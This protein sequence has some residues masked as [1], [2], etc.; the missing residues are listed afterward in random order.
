[1][2]NNAVPTPEPE[3]EIQEQP[4]NNQDPA[5]TSRAGGEDDIVAGKFEENYDE[6]SIQV[7]EG[8]EAVRKRP[9]MY[10][11]DNG[12]K[13]LHQMFREVIDNSVDEA[14]AGYC[15]QIKVTLHKDN[16]MS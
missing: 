6:S 16:S 2:P 5:I 13:G 11:G 12:R 10:V 7:L 14:L 3:D 8:L 4:A 1:M 9:G 15:D